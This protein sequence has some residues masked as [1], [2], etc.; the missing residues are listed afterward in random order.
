MTPYMTLPFDWA[1]LNFAA[2]NPPQM[3]LQLISGL[4]GLSSSWGA[5]GTLCGCHSEPN[6]KKGSTTNYLQGPYTEPTKTF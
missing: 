2:D 6:D 5:T 3:W 4:G 1:H